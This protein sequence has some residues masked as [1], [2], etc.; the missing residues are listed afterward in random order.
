LAHFSPNET[1]EHFRKR[2]GQFHQINA[3]ISISGGLERRI[4]GRQDGPENINMVLGPDL[5][6]KRDEPDPYLPADIFPIQ[7]CRIELLRLG[8]LPA[9]RLRNTYGS[10]LRIDEREHDVTRR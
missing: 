2:Q 8:T 10:D 9:V 4:T 1:G 3:L 7:S 5:V 6:N